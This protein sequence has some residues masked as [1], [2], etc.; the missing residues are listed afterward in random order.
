MKTDV[1]STD[2]FKM[3]KFKNHMFSDYHCYTK[4]IKFSGKIEAFLS[5]P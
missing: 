5:L 4:I 2:K 1:K 3:R